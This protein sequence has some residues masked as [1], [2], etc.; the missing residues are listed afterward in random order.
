[1][2]GRIQKTIYNNKKDKPYQRASFTVGTKY[3]SAAS[4]FM[5]PLISRML[6]E[7]KKEKKKSL[8]VGDQA[9]VQ[10]SASCLW[11]GSDSVR[12]FYVA[13]LEQGSAAGPFL[14]YYTICRRY[15]TSSS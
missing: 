9:P 2:G 5:V 7:D 15:C 3:L 10:I 12:P 14:D 8:R 6:L 11:T 1:M 4:G 13:T